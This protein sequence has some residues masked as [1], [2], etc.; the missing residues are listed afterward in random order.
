MAKE[1]SK[2]PLVDAFCSK[3]SGE[4]LCLT[5]GNLVKK[6]GAIAGAAVVSLTA[7][8]PVEAQAYEPEKHFKRI[9][10]VHDWTHLGISA[11]RVLSGGLQTVA[12]AME[13]SVAEQQ[14]KVV[15]G[16]YLREIDKL[17]AKYEQQV[18]RIKGKGDFST[19]LEEYLSYAKNQT[20]L[21][22]QQKARF[23]ELRKVL[24]ASGE[25][26][27][28]IL[29]TCHAHNESVDAAND[30]NDWNAKAAQDRRDA[31][32]NMAKR[33]D[34]ALVKKCETMSLNENG[35][36]DVVDVVLN[37]CEARKVT[38]KQLLQS[39]EKEAATLKKLYS[40]KANAVARGVS[41]ADRKMLSGAFQIYSSAGSILY[42][43]FDLYDANKGS[44]GYR[45]SP[46]MYAPFSRY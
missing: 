15:E 5:K 24:G 13:K 28:W 3:G 2:T 36:Y 14:L 30:G 41:A 22:T 45:L 37:I 21:N 1:K 46:S 42:H 26:S 43:S 39:L 25:A 31:C 9:R 7:L 40:N 4:V 16:E 12:G 6:I 11:A 34:A 32:L 19:L 35:K 10:Q 33:L 17:N 23:A 29:E 27:A 38:D 20:V 8:K 44:W 18:G